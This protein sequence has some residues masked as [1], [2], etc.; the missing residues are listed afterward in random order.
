M[1]YREYYKFPEGTNVG[2]KFTVTLFDTLKPDEL[3]PSDLGYAYADTGRTVFRLPDTSLV[4]T[5]DHMFQ[6]NSLLLE[7]PYFDTSN[8]TDM[9]SMFF[10]CEKLTTVPHYDTSNVTNMKSMFQNCKQLTSVP[11]FDTSNMTDMG[12][13]FQDCK[14]LKTIPAF[15]TSKVT[16]MSSMFSS[17][18]ALESLPALDCGAISYSNNYPLI[19]YG[20]NFDKLTD[21]GGFLNMKMSWDN[22]YGLQKCPNLTRESCINILNGLYDFTGNEETPAYNQGVL[23]VHANFLTAVGDDISIG[24]N[25]G[26]TITA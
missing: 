10:Y 23:K 13:M 2:F 24:T 26:W 20:D 16:T 8:V 7:A 19:S 17:C 9:E 3:C 18:Y 15:N 22:T 11:H 6:S 1:T 14:A 12:S 25:K 5:I 21:V 4:T